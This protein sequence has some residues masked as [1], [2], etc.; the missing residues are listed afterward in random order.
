MKGVLIGMKPT[1]SRS[2]PESI[3]R[4]APGKSPSRERWYVLEIRLVSYEW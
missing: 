2:E 1:E 4:S 3:T